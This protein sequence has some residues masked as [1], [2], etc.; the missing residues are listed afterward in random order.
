MSFFGAPVLLAVV[1]V[2]CSDSRPVLLSA[3]GSYTNGIV[4]KLLIWVIDLMRSRRGLVSRRLCQNVVG[5][6][7]ASTMMGSGTVWE[8]SQRSLGGGS[9]AP[10]TERERESVCVWL[11]TVSVVAV[12]AHLSRSGGS[13]PSGLATNRPSDRPPPRDWESAVLL[14]PSSLLLVDWVYTTSSLFHQIT[15]HA[16]N[17]QLTHCSMASPEGSE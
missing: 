13:D 11:W 7:S 4:Q 16:D 1:T 6:A 12:A 15:G 8:Q 10:R 5:M 3:A 17:P 9:K 14:R 2:A